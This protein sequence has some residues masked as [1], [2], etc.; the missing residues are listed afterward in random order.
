[1]EM[2]NIGVH[3]F[4]SSCVRYKDKTIL[5]LGSEANHGKSM[6]QLEGCNRGGSLISTET[7]VTD[8][9]GVA[10]YGSKNIWSP[11]KRAKGTERSDLPNQDEGVGIF[12][13]KEP[14]MPHFLE[15]SNIDLVIMPCIDGWFKTDVVPMGQFERCFHTYHSLSNFF[16]LSQC[17]TPDGFVMPIIDTDEKRQARGKFVSKFA[18]G[19]PYYMIRAKTPQ[20]LFD[21]I[22]KLL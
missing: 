3:P 19:R 5:L 16:G 13:E 9:E 20:I 8:G 6:G 10:L 1:M 7:T 14:E 21:E 11:K 22:D 15:P 4:H 2:D 18:E 17:L 12:F